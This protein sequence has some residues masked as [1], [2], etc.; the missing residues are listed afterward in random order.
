MRSILAALTLS[1]PAFHFL[2]FSR[3]QFY[4]NWYELLA[5]IKVIRCNK[6]SNKNSNSPKKK[7]PSASKIILLLKEGK[8][9]EIFEFD[10][11]TVDWFMMMFSL[12]D[13]TIFAYLR[14]RSGSPEEN[15]YQTCSVLFQLAINYKFLFACYTYLG[16]Q[17]NRLT[18]Q[19]K[20]KNNP[21]VLS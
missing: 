1:F 9:I 7:S 12:H 2:Q 16:Q 13:F 19:V 18:D 11:T 3:K 4:L 20:V 6:I 10:A 15:E 8:T 17:S 21:F 5:I 14:S